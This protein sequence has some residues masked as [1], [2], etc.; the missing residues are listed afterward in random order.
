MT[1]EEDNDNER[2]QEL[3]QQILA[4]QEF[5]L[6]NLIGREG[7]SFLKGESP[8]PKVV[9]VTTEINLFINQNLKDNSGALQAIL[10]NLVH[11]DQA[12]ISQYLDTPLIALEKMLEKILNNQELFYEFVKQVDL[13]WGQMYQE[14][15]YFQQPG[16]DAHPDD[17]YS[18]ESVTLQLRELL[19]MIQS[20][21]NS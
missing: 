3:Q 9:Q 8:I 10:H 6:A 12:T 20:L 18:H 7:G 15:P 16:Q 1:V 13:K 5:S 17:E 14:R 2:Y 21:S 19:Q 4:K 11:E